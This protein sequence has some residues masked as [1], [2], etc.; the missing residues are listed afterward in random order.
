MTVT[1]LRRPPPK[2]APPSARPRLEYFGPALVTAVLDRDVELE[3]AASGVR[4]WARLA[5]AIAYRPLIGDVVLAM[6]GDG[7]WYVVGVLEGHGPT[8][9]NAPGDLE[10]H[11]PN[12]AIRIAA[13]EGCVVSAPMVRVEAT[14]LDLIGDTLHEEFET[15]RRRISGMLEIRAKA[16]TTTVAETWRLVAR[17]IAGRGLDSVTI[18]AP[19]INL[20]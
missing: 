2:T 4:Q 5:V 1:A 6:A 8:V 19:S 15:A 18:D 13:A 12:G 10:L 14:S 11:A 20:G 9:L 17:R 16:I 3:I 7:A